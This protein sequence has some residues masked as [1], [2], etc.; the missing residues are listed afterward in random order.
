MSPE[1]NYQ[2]VEKSINVRDEETDLPY[3][4]EQWSKII[5]ISDKEWLFF[6]GRL[7]NEDNFSMI[8]SRKLM[9]LNIVTGRL[10]VISQC[11]EYMMAHSVLYIPQTIEE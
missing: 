3:P 4:V 11:P 1:T 7:L 5:K 6:M 2:W 10:T 8:G 9:K